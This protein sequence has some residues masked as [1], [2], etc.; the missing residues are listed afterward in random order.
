MYLEQ[1]RIFSWIAFAWGRVALPVASLVVY[2]LLA[3]HVLHP[4]VN[5]ALSI[6]RL[7]IVLVWVAG[8]Q[9]CLA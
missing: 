4:P 7:A 6:A 2:G 5:Y 1:R 3:F 9:V 8:F